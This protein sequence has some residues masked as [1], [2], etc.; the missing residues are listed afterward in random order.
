MKADPNFVDYNNSEIYLTNF[1][2]QKIERIHFNSSNNFMEQTNQIRN[3]DANMGFLIEKLVLVKDEFIDEDFFI[4]R[5]VEGGVGYFVSEKLKSE[6]E[7]AN[8][9]GIDFIPVD[10]GYSDLLWYYSF[11]SIN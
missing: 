3:R 1:G 2:F 6:I 5:Q 9:T 7:K 11:A 4:L 10:S 8:C